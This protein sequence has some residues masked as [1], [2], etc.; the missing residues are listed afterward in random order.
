MAAAVF[1]LV[2]GLPAFAQTPNAVECRIDLCYVKMTAN[3]FIPESII[4]KPGATIVWK[5]VDDKVHSL[6]IVAG[7]TRGDAVII[8]PGN[9]YSYVFRHEAR[10]TYF[11]AESGK[12]GTLIVGSASETPPTIRPKIDFTDSR[13]GISDVSMIRGGVTSIEIIPEMRALFVTVDVQSHD[14]L[15][16][17]IDRNLLDSRTLE[18]DAPFSIRVGGSVATYDEINASSEARTIRIALQAG[19]DSF[20]IRGNSIAAEP[21]GYQS[22]YSALSE[23]ASVIAAYKEKGIVTREADNLL[24]QATDAAPLGKYHFATDLANEAM[25]AAQRADRIAVVATSV[26]NEAETSIKTTKTLGGDV[27]QAEELLDHTREIYS[28]GGY[29]EAL[30]LANYARAAALTKINPLLIIGAIGISSAAVL[31]A[32]HRKLSWNR[33]TPAATIKQ[34]DGL[35]LQSVF[36]EKPHLREDDRLV[37]KYIID[38]GGEAL[39][40]EIRNK[41]GLP[42][43]TAWRLMRRL[44]REELVEI[45]KFGNQNMVK[46]KLK[47]EA[48]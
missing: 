22:A 14:V 21:L 37:L 32:Y 19:T 9:S 12:S 7:Q 38:N 39:L 10:F 48:Q 16:M 34:D 29:E 43:S 46:Y 11:D 40:A 47:T 41:F 26:M 13:S 36:V 4:V 35:S 24:L 8:S 44:E 3:G 28:Y 1:C 45:T 17:T 5:N 25:L 27:A 31:Y 30:N 42:K 6:E 33:K 15:Q 23:A 2:G 20:L 18:R